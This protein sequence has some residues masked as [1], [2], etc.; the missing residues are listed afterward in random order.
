[1]SIKAKIAADTI[2]AMKQRS[3]GKGRLAA[4]RLLQSAIKQ[5]EIDDQISLD[6]TQIHALISK[7]IKQRNDS[8]QYFAQGNRQDLVDKEQREIDILKT[9]LPQ[10][11]S[12]DALD[13]II[14]DTIRKAN[15]VSVK[16]MGKVMALLKSSI[17]GRAD[18]GQIGLKVKK[19]LSSS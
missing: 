1:M 8:I 10:P 14:H 15:A 11:L 9:Y 3:A 2:E 7:M 19:L 12:S 13:E 6:D 16:D 4:L 18:M 5:K 17:Q